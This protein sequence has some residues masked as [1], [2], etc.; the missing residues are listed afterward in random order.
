MSDQ[1][2]HFPPIITVLIAALA[3]AFSLFGINVCGEDFEINQNNF[4]IVIRMKWTYHAESNSSVSVPSIPPEKETSQDIPKKRNKSILKL[5]QKNVSKHKRKTKKKKNPRK[6]KTPS[7]KRKDKQRLDE[8]LKTK[9]STSSSKPNSPQ[10]SAETV[11]VIMGYHQ[12]SLVISKG[13]QWLSWVIIGYLDWV[14]VGYR[15]LLS[16]IIYV[17]GDKLHTIATERCHERCHT[18]S[19][20]TVIDQS[21]PNP[22]DSIMPNKP[23]H[24]PECGA[25]NEARSAHSKFYIECFQCGFKKRKAGSK[26]PNHVCR[27]KTKRRPRVGEFYYLQEARQLRFDR[28]DQ[29][30][31]RIRQEL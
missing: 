24:C 15:W 17:F 16:V 23:S 30:L 5:T 1:K 7:R 14:I 2:Q 27:I 22:K 31:K 11:T 6:K 8:Y 25:R 18:N 4:G 12:L 13:Y 10:S 26:P 28:R 29:Y 20:E 19:S 21:D 3:N 9:Y